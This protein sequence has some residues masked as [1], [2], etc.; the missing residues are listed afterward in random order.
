MATRE[1]CSSRGEVKMWFNVANP[2][3]LI[4]RY[5]DG[6]ED[7]RNKRRMLQYCTFTALM[8]NDKGKLQPSQVFTSAASNN[9]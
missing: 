3:E 7:K 2:R 6:N 5:H 1:Y 4:W 8:E 9:A